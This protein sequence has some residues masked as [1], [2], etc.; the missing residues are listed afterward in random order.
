M[1]FVLAGRRP[2]SVWSQGA[3]L[4]KIMNFVLAGRRPHSVWSQGA[5]LRKSMKRCVTMGVLGGLWLGGCVD[6]F[7]DPAEQRAPTVALFDPAAGVLPFPHDALLLSSSDGTLDVPV[8]DD[9][10]DSDPRRALNALDGFSITEAVRIPF[11]RSL[12]PSSVVV[13]ASVRVFEGFAGPE[14]TAAD[15]AAFVDPSATELLV[16]ALRPFPAA[17]TMVVV[18]TNG[19]LDSEGRPVDAA[20]VF[21]L[22]RSSNPLIDSEGRARRSQL[23]DDVDAAALEPLRALTSLACTPA[24]V[25]GLVDDDLVMCLPFTTQSALPVLQALND[26]VDDVHAQAGGDTAQLR[27]LPVPI[28][29]TEALGLAGAA[30][31]HVGALRVPRLLPLDEPLSG[32]FENEDGDDVGAGRLPVLQGEEVVPVLITVPKTQKPAAG[33]GLVVFQHG[34]TRDRTD[35]IAL[36][37]ACAAAGL[38]A[39]AIDLPL[40]GLTGDPTHVFAALNP[41]IDAAAAAYASPFF[42]EQ[43]PQ[44]RTRNLDLVDNSSGEAGPDDVVDASG[45][46]FLNLASL[47]TTRDNLRQALADIRTL[48]LAAASLDVDGDGVSDIDPAS[49]AFVGHSVGAIIGASVCAL[50]DDAAPVFSSCVLANPGAQLLR[51]FQGSPTFGPRLL[52]GLRQAGIADVDL[53]AFL[54]LGQSVL[55]GADPWAT[56]SLL[57]AQR[58]PLLIIDVANDA[59]VA[60]RQPLAPLAGGLPFLEALALPLATSD[61]SSDLPQRVRVRFDVGDHGS[62]L[63]PAADAAVTASMQRLVVTF[64]A[65]RGHTVDVDAP[66][67]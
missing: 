67:R 15:V 56:F 33:Y 40:H 5:R 38:V 62:L 20:P 42:E 29:G 24:R 65:S 47:L 59:V 30:N 17:T 25:R 27:V 37:D 6:P 23:I 19:L 43:R 12:D 8:D 44:E 4:R 48:G 54:G 34:I 45:S 64:V 41:A 57:Q 51:L 35:V 66:A 13:G 31:L 46:H 2:Y 36:A 9:A 16:V 60:E 11:S 22:A 55:D 49:R 32:R 63:S 10:L 28:L 53:D 1:N 26:I 58:R 18:V 7:L 61:R 52:A 3:R 21:K 50:D 14:R 39:V